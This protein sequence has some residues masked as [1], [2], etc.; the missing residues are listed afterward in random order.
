MRSGRRGRYAWTESRREGA[1]RAGGTGGSPEPCIEETVRGCPPIVG[2]F[3]C[4]RK[5]F[6]LDS[7]IEKKSPPEI[8]HGLAELL[9]SH[10]QRAAGFLQIISPGQPDGQMELLLGKAAQKVP[11]EDAVGEVPVM[12]GKAVQKCLIA[13][14]RSGYIQGEKPIH[15]ILAKLLLRKDGTA[16]L[17]IDIGPEAGG[18]ERAELAKS[19]EESGPGNRTVFFITDAYAMAGAEL[20]DDFLHPELLLTGKPSDMPHMWDAAFRRLR[21]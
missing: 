17:P 16:D 6:I 8:I 18:G 2:A 15:P 12:G 9:L 19:G 20:A 10:P 7:S 3:I 5:D 13:V 1:D 11:Q 14:G 21:F 4:H